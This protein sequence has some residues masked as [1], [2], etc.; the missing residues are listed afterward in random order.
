MAIRK[1]I[2]KEFDVLKQVCKPVEEFD[3]KLM[4]LLDDMRDTLT[5]S[6]G[7][8]LAAPQIGVLKRIFLMDIGD[9]IIECINPEI[10][11]ESGKQR[12]LEGCLSCPDDWGYT[13]RP[14]KVKLKAQNRRGKYFVM[15]LTELGAQCASHEN[16]H[17]DGKL[18]V[19]KIV[20]RVN[21]EDLQ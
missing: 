1:I 4:T 9:G 11:K 8:G 16:D 20:E 17:L 10:V 18:F 3:E 15:N 21:P 7:V 5:D 13:V 19:E 2:T 14:A 12:V 6:K